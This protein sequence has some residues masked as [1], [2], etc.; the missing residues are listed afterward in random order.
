M[1]EQRSSVPTVEAGQPAPDDFRAVIGRF[2]SGVT[3]I[4]V[5]ADAD[6]F[7]STASAMTSLSLE[8]PMLLI[9]MNRSSRTAAAIQAER[10][11]GVSILAE[12]QGDLAARFASSRPD[13]FDGVDYRTGEYGQPLL[14]GALAT[15]EC[16]VVETV[17]G[18]T[19][20]VFLAEVRAM[21]AIDGYPL[22]YYRGGFGRLELNL[23][24]ALVERTRKW[25]ASRRELWGQPL[26]LADAARE[27]SAPV[28]ALQSALT[29]L[30]ADGSVTQTESGRFIVAPVTADLVEDSLI[31]RGLIELGVA[32]MTVG[33]LSR[34]QLARLRAA[35]ETA[36]AYVDGDHYTDPHRYPAANEAFHEL[37]VEMSGS[38]ALL[39]AYRRVGSVELY[40]AGRPAL[41]AGEPVSAVD[42]D[43]VE[44][45]EAYEAG[46]VAWAKRVLQRH[47]D[48]GIALARAALARDE[49]PGQ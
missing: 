43:H 9:C 6:K 49:D 12:H 27:M 20:T 47:I 11:F 10:R 3:V 41:P 16:D 2:A 21:S 17:G 23:D 35:M 34:E 33:K 4:T 38:A 24:Q 30:A 13:K 7:G 32:E 36:H 1:N 26:D 37:L 8:P 48:S 18:G 44:L 22:A 31:G 28:G 46:D 39:R 29:V 45:M 40:S 42:H 5:A 25:L 19:H 15:L 14:S